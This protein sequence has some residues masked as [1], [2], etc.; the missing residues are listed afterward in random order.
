MS[1]IA[2]TAG[3]DPAPARLCGRAA[4]S[5]LAEGAHLGVREGSAVVADPREVASEPAGVSDAHGPG[6]L[7]TGLRRS[8][9]NAI[10]A[11][12]PGPISCGQWARR[13]TNRLTA[14]VLRTRPS[15]TRARLRPVYRGHQ[16]HRRI[17]KVEHSRLRLQRLGPPPGLRRLAVF[18]PL[19]NDP[20][21]WMR[22]GLTGER[23][24]MRLCCEINSE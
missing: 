4:R 11:R 9:C 5:C 10:A 14:P 16:S 3:V 7:T 12:R 20:P 23:L 2:S 6:I 24:G 8:W 15:P 1:S 17:A 19:R 13:P 22:T 21:A 18:P